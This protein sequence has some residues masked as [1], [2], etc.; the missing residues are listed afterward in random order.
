MGLDQYAFTVPESLVGDTQVDIPELENSKVELAY[1]RKFN[2]LEG[3]MKKVYKN[4]HGKSEEF[5]CNTVRLMPEDLDQLY[6]ALM[7]KELKSEIGFFFGDEELNDCDVE[8]TLQFITEA[9]EKI[10]KGNAVFY[11]SWW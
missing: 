1:W 10:S 6:A 3:W 5:N 2:H 4:K 8:K 11:Y 9:R 7:N